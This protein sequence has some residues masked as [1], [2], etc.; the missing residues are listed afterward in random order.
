M[1]NEQRPRAGGG[2]GA[3]AC[4]EVEVLSTEKPDPPLTAPS[5]APFSLA[6]QGPGERGLLSKA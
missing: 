6:P 1:S 3:E 4:A 2:G 5:R